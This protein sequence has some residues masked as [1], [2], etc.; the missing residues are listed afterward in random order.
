MDLKL[1]QCCD[2]GNVN[3]ST[4]KLRVVETL[5]QE[6]VRRNLHDAVECFVDVKF[7]PRVLISCWWN[8]GGFH[9]RASRRVG[10]DPLGYGMKIL[11]LPFAVYLLKMNI[12]YVFTL[13]VFML[14]VL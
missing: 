12:L 9:E 8:R 1:R 3:T 5:D 6:E 7:D 4:S 13:R 10:Y 14:H 11:E 2:F